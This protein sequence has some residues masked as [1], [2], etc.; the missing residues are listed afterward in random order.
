MWSGGKASVRPRERPLGEPG[1]EAVPGPR[2][3]DAPVEGR[4]RLE[5]V[6]E[7]GNLRRALHQGR[8]QQGVPGS[9]GRTGDDRGGS[10]NTHG[11]PRRAALREGP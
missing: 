1:E 9:A 4:D 8:R 7:P 10:W 6:L 3:E 2:G 5:R 11:P